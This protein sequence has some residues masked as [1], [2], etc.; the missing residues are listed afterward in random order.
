MKRSFL[1]TS[2]LAALFGA[3]FLA[4]CAAPN[5]GGYAHEVGATTPDSVGTKPPGASPRPATATPPVPVPPPL[6]PEQLALREGIDMYNKGD[7][8]DAIKRL[9]VPEIASGSKAGQITA[10]KYTAFSYCVTSRPVPCRQ[11]FE[12]AFKLDPAF[13]LAPG[14]HGHPL[15]GKTFLRAKKNGK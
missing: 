8:N 3:A 9:G 6:S 1:P 13:D 4:G 5:N 2:L 12:K 14:E 15:W 10:L 7:F 11:Q